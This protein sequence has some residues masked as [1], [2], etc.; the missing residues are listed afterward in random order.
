MSFNPEMVSNLNSFETD[1]GKEFDPTHVVFIRGEEILLTRCNWSG[2]TTEW[3]TSFHEFSYHGVDNPTKEDVMQSI[4]KTFDLVIT[5]DAEHPEP[6]YRMDVVMGIGSTIQTKRNHL[7]VFHV[8]DVQTTRKDTGDCKWFKLKDIRAL[9]NGNAYYGRV[10][11]QLY[12][13]ME[14]IDAP[15]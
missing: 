10:Y 11:D 13:I 9:V 8:R 14:L 3:S 2:G 12:H 15:N 7:F 5:P 1:V 6:R 4:H